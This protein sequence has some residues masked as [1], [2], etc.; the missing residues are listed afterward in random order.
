MILKR[1]I[2]QAFEAQQE[3]LVSKSGIISRRFLEQ[4]KPSGNHIEVISGVRRCGKSTLMKEIIRNKYQKTAYF[5]FEDAR[6]HGFEVGDF[7]KLDEVIGSGMEAY[8]FDEIQNVPSW[9][10]FI[11]QLHERNEK[12]Y[13][14]GSNA[15]LLSKELGTRLTGRNIRHELYPF[16]YEEFLRY[17]LLE[18]NAGTFALH[19]RLGGFPE[20]LDSENTEVMQNL[21]KDIV[22]RD[23]AIRYGIRNTDSLMDI[24]LYMLSN[25]GK[26]F[27]FNSLRKTFSLGSANTVSDYL[28]WLGDSY[29]LFYLPKFSWSAKSMAINPRKVYAIDNG[30]INANTLSFNE[31]RGRLLENAVFLF[32]KQ[33]NF[34]LYYFRE[35]S[36]CDFV[37]FENKKCKMLI[38]V[39][40]AVN[41]DNLKREMDGLQEAMTYFGLKEGYFVTL[42]QQDELRQ[43]DMLVHMIPAYKFMA[44]MR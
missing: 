27:S 43:N 13:I 3:Q 41:Q 19:Q 5:N 26:E 28:S 2:E 11:R 37:V 9:E 33:R 6:V 10:V 39:C 16:S 29:L 4:F 1:D 38:Q 20:Y 42:D 12:V 23:I 34:D 22:F 24:S 40:V 25:I 30:L 18:N 35:Q 32:L 36:E 17:R 44:E 15:T 21:L 7:A 8:F 14:T 31:D